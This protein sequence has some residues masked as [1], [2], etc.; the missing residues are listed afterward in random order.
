MANKQYINITH[1]QINIL[2][3]IVAEI[4]MLVWVKCY[5][6]QNLRIEITDILII[7][8]TLGVYNKKISRKFWYSIGIFLYFWVDFRGKF[9]LGIAVC[10]QILYDGIYLGQYIY[11]FL[12]GRLWLK[13]LSIGAMWTLATVILPCRNNLYFSYWLIIERWAWVS[14]LAIITDIF[15]IIDDRKNKLQT[16]PTYF[17]TNIVFLIILFGL[18]IN[19]LATFKQVIEGGYSPKQFVMKSIFTILFFIGF[20][21]FAKHFAFKT[22]YRYLVD[23]VMI[24]ERF[25]FF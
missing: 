16:I 19:V 24:L 18:F 14:T 9:L 10:L 5:V 3:I 2:V 1:Q 6:L 21:F 13:P 12:R 25:L 7:W 15:D 20:T 8:A 11:V 22:H 17:S 4:V 23:S